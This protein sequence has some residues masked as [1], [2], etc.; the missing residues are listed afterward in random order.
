MTLEIWE[1]KMTG[2][3]CGIR[4]H[5]YRALRSDQETLQLCQPY[6]M[7]LQVG[8][9]P[10][11]SRFRGYVTPTSLPLMSPPCTLLVTNP[12]TAGTYLADLKHDI[13]DCT[14]I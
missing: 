4:K 5:I 9:C 7:G 1:V 10:C 14:R 11:R 3:R 12:G 2:T 6:R 8:W 13:C